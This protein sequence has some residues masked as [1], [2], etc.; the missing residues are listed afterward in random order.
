MLYNCE[1]KPWTYTSNI[2]NLNKVFIFLMNPLMISL[3]SL[4]IFDL[5][6]LSSGGIK[7]L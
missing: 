7:S 4:E 6:L 2:Q 5:F 3:I 1:Y